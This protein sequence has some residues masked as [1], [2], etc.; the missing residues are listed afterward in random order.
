MNG[1]PTVGRAVVSIVEEVRSA[2]VAAPERSRWLDLPP[3][4]WIIRMGGMLALSARAAIEFVTPGLSWRREL[5]LQAIFIFKVALVPVLL[6]NFATGITI[7]V[8]VSSILSALGAIDRAGGAV[9]VAFLREL[10][11]F[12]TAAII[13]GSVGA[14][15]TSELGARK[16]RDELSA[17]EVLGI[18]PVRAM[19]VPRI[20]ALVLL[21]PIMNMIALVAGT[22]GSVIAATVLYLGTP[23]AFFDQFLANTNFIDL[24]ASQAKILIFGLLIGVIA[25]YKGLNASGGAEGVGRAVNE[26]V[27]ASLIAV[28]GVTIVYTQLLLALYPDISALR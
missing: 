15:I 27:V 25:C 5:I 11:A 17:L 10:G 18:N 14:T 19:V 7:G 28:V 1:Q 23:Q 12:L 4:I 22:A 21:M 9:P 13:A 20:V 24:W 8:Q 26:S 2:P 6:V 3:L 16:I